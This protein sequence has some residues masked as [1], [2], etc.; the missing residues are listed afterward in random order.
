GP[1]LAAIIIAPY[2]KGHVA[3][4]VL[5]A[6]LAMIILM[7]VSRWYRVQ[8]KNTGPAN[9]AREISPFPTKTVITGIS[10]LLILIFSKFVY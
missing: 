6:L 10:V 7:Q 5:A 8:T 3:W 1:L 9:A 4:F 2:G